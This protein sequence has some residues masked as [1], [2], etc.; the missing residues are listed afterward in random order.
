MY[1]EMEISTKIWTG[2]FCLFSYAQSQILHC[3]LL[4]VLY[5]LLD[6]TMDTRSTVTNSNQP[7]NSSGVAGE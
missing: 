1:T 7:T 3:R 5:L 6:V 2:V 4:S